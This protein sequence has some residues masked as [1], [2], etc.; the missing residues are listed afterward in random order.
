MFRN[1]LSFNDFVLNGLKKKQ[2]FLFL[3]PCNL[4]IYL[5]AFKFLLYGLNYDFKKEV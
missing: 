4:F 2:G 3:I 5:W 1:C